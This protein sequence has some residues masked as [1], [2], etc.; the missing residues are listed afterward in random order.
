MSNVSENMRTEPSVE[1]GVAGCYAAQAVRIRLEVGHGWLDAGQLASLEAGSL[2]ELDAPSCQ[3]VELYAGSRL[4][5]RGELIG[6]EG[7]YALRVD[8]LTENRA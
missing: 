6:F 1:P 2:V 7:K 8:E 3:P 5:A 4:I